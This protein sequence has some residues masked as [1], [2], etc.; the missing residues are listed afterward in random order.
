M[1]LTVVSPELLVNVI[2]RFGGDDGI[3]DSEREEEDKTV[4]LSVEVE[5]MMGPPVSE[6][7][8]VKVDNRVVPKVRVVDNS[9]LALDEFVHIYDDEV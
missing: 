9:P 6:P 8:K 1:R 2:V 5:P 4:V 3:K 7:D